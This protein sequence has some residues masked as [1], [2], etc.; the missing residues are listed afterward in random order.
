MMKEEEIRKLVRQEC[1]QVMADEGL[2]TADVIVKGDNLW[3]VDSSVFPIVR[4]MY[5]LTVLG[6]VLVLSGAYRKCL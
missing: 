4:K 2:T 1:R 3:F 5:T 6:V